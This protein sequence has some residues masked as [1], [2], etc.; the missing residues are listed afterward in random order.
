MKS[1]PRWPFIAT[2]LELWLLAAPRSAGA[3]AT[4]TTTNQDFPLETTLDNPCTGEPI[5]FTGQ[6]HLMIHATATPSGH[7]E[8]TVHSNLQDVSG[9]GTE[10]GAAF[11]FQAASTTTAQVEPGVETTIMINFRIIGPGAGNNFLLHNLTHLTVNANG[12]ATATVQEV[13]TACH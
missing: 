5:L 11:H 1:H 2:A 10:S 7:F 12:E 9:T 6:V 4:A 13:F 8:T 3:Q